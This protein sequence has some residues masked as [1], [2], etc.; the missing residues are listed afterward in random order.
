V[1]FTQNISDVLW[2]SRYIHEPTRSTFWETYKRSYITEDG[3]FF[4][5]LH[6]LRIFLMVYRFHTAAQPISQMGIRK[7]PKSAFDAAIKEY[8]EDSETETDGESGG[9]D[10]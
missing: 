6:Y 5:W 1:T 7:L 8:Q 10:E 9:T 2:T 3:K 4:F